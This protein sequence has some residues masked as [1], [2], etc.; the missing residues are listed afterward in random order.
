MDTNIDGDQENSNTISITIAAAA[1]PEFS[2]YAILLILV[3]VVGGFFVVR[4]SNLT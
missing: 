3:T 2:D 1:V 4:K